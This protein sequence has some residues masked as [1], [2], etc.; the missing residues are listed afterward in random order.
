MHKIL[1]KKYY[2][3]EKFNKSNIDKKDKNTIIIYRK[4]KKKLTLQ[5]Y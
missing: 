1:F 5:K 3:I 4:Y 2:F